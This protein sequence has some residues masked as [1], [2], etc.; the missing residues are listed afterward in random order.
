MDSV[1]RRMAAAG[2]E[3]VVVLP[4]AA[5]GLRAIIAIHSRRSARRSAAS[6]IWPYAARRRR[7]ADVLRLSRGD[8]LQGGGRRARPRR[9]QGGGHRRPGDAAR[10]RRCSAPSAAS[11]T[12][13]AAATSPPRTSARRRRDMDIDRAAR[14]A[15]SPASTPRRAARATRRRSPRSASSRASRAGSRTVA[16]PTWPAGTSSSRASATSARTSCGCCVEAGAR[17]TVAD[18]DAGARRGASAALGADG[19]RRRRDPAELECDIFAPCA[20]GGALND[21]TIPQLRCAA[22]VRRR[23]QPARATRASADAARRR[24]ILYA[25]DYVVNAGGIIN[26]A[27]EFVGYDAGQRARARRARASTRPSA[28]CSRAPTRE[29]SPG[30]GRRP[31]GRGAHRRDRRRWPAAR[32]PG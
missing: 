10:P 24:G 25:P 32:R 21:A 11:S 12:S 13:S 27:E 19:G 22:V 28:A 2:H 26:I 1:L 20:L 5:T 7:A 31:P 4:R 16:T 8:D 23:Q 29:T 14:R 15:G 9:R 17:V 6:G 3:Q 18:I 30:R